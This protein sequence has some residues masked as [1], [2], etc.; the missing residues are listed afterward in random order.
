[1]HWIASIDFVQGLHSFVAFSTSGA[2]FFV[3][4]VFIQRE[5]LRKN[6]PQFSIDCDFKNA[7]KS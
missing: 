6:I 4:V 1:M 3:D 5:S 2:H 7:E